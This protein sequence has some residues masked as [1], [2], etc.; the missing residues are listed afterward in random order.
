[1][2]NVLADV[3]QGILLLGQRSF[4]ALNIAENSLCSTGRLTAKPLLRLP[5]RAGSDGAEA[6]L[7]PSNEPH[8]LLG[9]GMG[10]SKL[11]DIIGKAICTR[12]SGFKI[13]QNTRPAWLASSEGERL[14]LDFYL[15]E[16]RIAFEVQGSQHYYFTPH[17]HSTF[18]NFKAQI[19]RDDAKR[20]ICEETGV[21][22]FEV[23]SLDEFY[24]LDA[25]LA[26]VVAQHKRRTLE[27]YIQQRVAQE[28]INN[29]Q[30]QIKGQAIRQ[31]IAE[32]TNAGRL[33]QL[34]KLLTKNVYDLEFSKERIRCISVIAINEFEGREGKKKGRAR[35]YEYEQKKREAMQNGTPLKRFR[36][37]RR[38]L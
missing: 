3:R 16:L 6:F 22:L 17:F 29:G 28:L 27:D 4:P 32:T 7:F 33:N 12:F 26:Q 36:K 31:L 20:H 38:L 19:R 10:K 30:I 9:R 21:Q 14:E 2:F 11:Q 34:K 8:D 5:R 15:P 37:G 25:Q 1:M 18:E 13:K 23:T 24:S 35:W